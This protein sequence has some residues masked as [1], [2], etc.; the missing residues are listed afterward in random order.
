MGSI[1]GLLNVGAVS[2][3]L[4]TCVCVSDVVGQY[5]G[6]GLLDVDAVLWGL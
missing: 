3:V 1:V 4:E 5:Q 6:G 2:W